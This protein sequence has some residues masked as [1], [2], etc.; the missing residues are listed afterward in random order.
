[1]E[2]SYYP[3]CTLKAN[4]KNL[5]TTTLPL[6]EL[7]DIQAKELDEW[8]CCGVSFSQA[9]DNLMQQLAPIRT[10][11][12][13]KQSGNKKLLVPCDMCYNTLRRASNFILEDSEK[14][15]TIKEFM[16]LEDDHYNGDEIEVIHL[17]TILKDYTKGKISD[18]IKKPAQGLKIAPYY[19]CMILRPKSVA[20]DDSN[21]PTIMEDILKELQVD[22]VD[23][24]FRNECCTSYQVVNE[25]DIVKQRT[26]QLVGSAAK[27]GAEMIVLTC[28]LCNYNLDAVQKDILEE[29]ASF[30]ALP[31][32]YLSQLM[33]LMLGI[34]PQVNDFSL[35]YIDPQPILKKKGLL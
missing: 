6:L 1:M 3:G 16:T 18:L 21:D 33:A 35:H 8:Y 22:I 12:R 29:D 14:K 19:G 13:A 25:R 34:D 24:P 15:E 5:E 23:F 17:L 26:K 32:L 30:Q 11:I 20:V 2:I 7:F 9:S 10:L 31:V 27:R 4:A 28:P